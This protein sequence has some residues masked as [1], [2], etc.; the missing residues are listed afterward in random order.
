MATATT[1]VRI[2]A[3]NI[4]WKI[5]QSPTSKRFIGVC[6]Q[7]NLTLEGDTEIELRSLIPEAIHLLMLDLLA[8]REIDQYLKDRGWKAFNLPRRPVQNIK[9]DVPWHIIAASAK[10]DTERRAR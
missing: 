5:F 9:F 10:R 7:L 6:D 3:K 2:D 4:G 8:D 1:V